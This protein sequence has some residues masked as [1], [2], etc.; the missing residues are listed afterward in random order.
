[1]SVKEWLIDG[2]YSVNPSTTNLSLFCRDIDSLKKAMS[3][4]AFRF[5]SHSVQTVYE[6]ES[7]N[8]YN[9]FSAWQAIKTYYAAFFAAHAILRF[10][11][12][13]YSHL[14]NGHVRHLASRSASDTESYINLP[15]SYYLIFIQDTDVKFESH[16]RSHESFWNCFNLFL[17]ELSNIALTI[18]ASEERRQDL[19]NRIT[20]LSTA[21]CNVNR[22]RSGNWLSYMR[23]EINY[24]SMPGVWFPIPKS[25]PDFSDLYRN[26]SRWRDADCFTEDTS[27]IKNEFE[28]FFLT[29]FCVIDLALSIGLDYQS[30]LHKVG[31]R[32]YNF[33]YLLSSSAS[34]NNTP[35]GRS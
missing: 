25:T 26:I 8:S 29:S 3:L 6:L 27:Y 1:M 20:N 30:L 13:S 28:R 21:L 7:S 12:K 17:V 5:L 24:K 15:T 22:H 11:G 18:R 14:E 4:D 23:N 33:N 32:S 10:F 19:S 35:N 31:R 2:Q 16:G 9:K 34:K